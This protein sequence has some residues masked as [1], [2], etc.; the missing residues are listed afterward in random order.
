MINENRQLGQLPEAWVWARLGDLGEVNLGKTPNKSQYRNSGKYKIIKFRDIQGDKISWDK[1][2][3][4][5]VLGSQDIINQLRIL[6]RGDVLVAASAHSSEHIGR[7]VVYVYEIPSVYDKVL[8]VGELLCIRLNN[9]V[10]NPRITYYYLLSQAAYHSIQSHVRGVHLLASE[11]RQIAIPLP[12]LPEQY[13]IV[14]K[15]EELF[16][17]VDAGVEALKKVKAQLRGYRQAVLKHAFEG[18]LTEESCDRHKGEIEPAS[19][20]LERI[21]QEQKKNVKGKYKGLPPLDTS[22]LPELPDGWAYLTLDHLVTSDKNSIKRGPFGS[23]IKKAFFVPYGYKVYEQG[24]VIYNDFERGGYFIDDNKFHELKDFEVKAGDVL[25]SCSGTVGKI[26]IVPEGMQP[27]VINQ[28]LLKITLDNEVIDTLYFTYLLRSRIDDIILKNTRGSAMVNISSARDL[29]QIPLPI[30]SLAEQHKIVE[31]IERCSSVADDI[32]KV[33]E[34]SLMQ[35]ERLRQSILRRAFEGKLVPQDP[36]DEPA[37][38][39]LERIRVERTKRE[40][41]AKTPNKVKGKVLKPG[42]LLP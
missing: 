24:N 34:Q 5:F 36:T 21:K 31:E 4:G 41:E 2:D 3:R 22:S 32:E 6:E 11:A 25:M 10:L 39:L 42:R 15:I 17:R 1:C 13:R 16:T 19:V 27:G 30:P 38:K 28:A 40:V 8:F 35:A 7:K 14:A 23:S 37:E 29:R 12:P 18:K 26:A 20:L 9:Q 33:M